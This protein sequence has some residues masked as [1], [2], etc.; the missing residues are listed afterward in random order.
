MELK[1]CHKNSF[2]EKWIESIVK[3]KNAQKD[4]RLRVLS[5]YVRYA[6]IAVIYPLKVYYFNGKCNLTVGNLQLW[7]KNR[8]K[9]LFIFFNVSFFC[10]IFSQHHPM[11]ACQVKT[12]VVNPDDGRNSAC[13]TENVCWETKKREPPDAWLCY[14]GRATFKKLHFCEI[15]DD[16]KEAWLK[17]SVL[18]N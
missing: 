1:H 12:N 5:D 10:R 11:E 17:S 8:G 18:H 13:P 4:L 14:E 16:F 6:W 9:L 3:K 15:E 2:K 7:R